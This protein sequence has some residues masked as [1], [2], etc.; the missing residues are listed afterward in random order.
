VTTRD[1]WIGASGT[2]LGL[3]TWTRALGEPLIV[4][5]VLW[6]ALAVVASRWRRVAQAG[7]ALVCAVLPLLGYAAL[8]SSVTGNFELVVEGSTGWALYSRTAQFADCDEFA[9]PPRT[10]FLCESR[11]QGRR[12][13]PDY[14]GWDDASPA[15][16]RFGYAPWGGDDLQ[17]FALAA[18]KAQP[19]DYASVVLKDSLRYF[20]PGYNDERAASGTTYEH[21]AIDNRDPAFE[22]DAYEVVRSYWSDDP[23][24]VGDATETLGSLQEVLRVSPLVMLGA[25]LAA[26]LGLPV[27]TSRSRRVQLLLLAAALALLVV[28]TATA[29]YA[30]RYSLPAAGPLVG[31]G[32]IGVWQIAAWIRRRRESSEP[33]PT[34]TPVASREG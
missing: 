13:G 10:R 17:S 9:P 1:A 14:Y 20:L 27:G 6:C 19:E 18:I 16:Q 11:P 22:D 15:R 21:L 12:P 26:G 30:A 28:P 29:A 33:V 2:L 24:S 8:N 7:V 5:L 4:I 23:L 32:A 25:L 31:A 3:T 34:S